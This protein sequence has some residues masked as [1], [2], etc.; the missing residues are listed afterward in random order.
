[1]KLSSLV[2]LV[3]I[4]VGLLAAANA[5]DIERYLKLRGM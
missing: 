4:G 1:M 2:L 3:L 5:K